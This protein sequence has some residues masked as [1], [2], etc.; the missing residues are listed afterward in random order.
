MSATLTKWRMKNENYSS[1]EQVKYIL[2]SSFL[3]L[4]FMIPHS[5]FLR[6]FGIRSRF[7]SYR[8]YSLCSQRNLTNLLK[9]YKYEWNFER[10][11]IDLL[12]FCLVEAL[13]KNIFCYIELTQISNHPLPHR[14]GEGWVRFYE[15]NPRPIIL[16]TLEHQFRILWRAD[17]IRTPER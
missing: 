3:I 8:V 13:Q 6:Q 5:S 1:S 2:H 14:E 11:W 10:F 9:S 15:T 4:H 16:E 17:S 7:A 12:D